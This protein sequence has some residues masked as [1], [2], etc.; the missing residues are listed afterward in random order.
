MKFVI[1][2][3]R[4]LVT[5]TG[6]GATSGSR[7]DTLATPGLFHRDFLVASQNSEFSPL[8]PLLGTSVFFFGVKRSIISREKFVQPATVEPFGGRDGNLQYKNMFII[9]LREMVNIEII[10]K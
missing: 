3:V 9:V 6:S 4:S 8:M 1:A 5:K 7:S 10:G 2:L